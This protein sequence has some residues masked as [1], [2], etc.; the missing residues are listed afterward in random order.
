MDTNK[1]GR[2]QTPAWA[3]SS[4][5]S[6]YERDCPVGKQLSEGQET[7]HTCNHVVAGKWVHAQNLNQLSTIQQKEKA[8]ATY[9]QQQ[10]CQHQ[11]FTIKWNLLTDEDKKTPIPPC[12]LITSGCCMEAECVLCSNVHQRKDLVG[13]HVLLC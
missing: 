1:V 7:A 8:A 13:G 10:R 9:K 4:F 12:Q 11:M 2:Q 3:W 6:A 5:E